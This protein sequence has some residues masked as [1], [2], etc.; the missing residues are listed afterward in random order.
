MVNNFKYINGV[1]LQQISSAIIDTG[2]FDTVQNLS[3]GAIIWCKTDYIDLL[4]DRLKH[5]NNKY[6]L[7][8]H[9]SDYSI[10]EAK[11]NSKPACIQRWFAQNVDYKHNQLTPLPIG[12]ENHYGPNKG[13][14]LD[15]QYILNSNN[16]YTHSPSK[17]VDRVYVNFTC[18]TNPNYRYNCI[19]ELTTNNLCE[20]HNKLPQ[21]EWYNDMKKFLFIA[22]PRGNGID[23]H[24]TWEALFNGSIPLVDRHFMFDEY[25]NLPII[26]IDNWK[27]VTSEFLQPYI[28]KYDNYTCFDNTQELMLDFWLNKITD[29]AKKLQ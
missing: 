5:C 18:S 9:C 25:K 13:S 22:S 3:S 16:N 19:N 26:Q 15:L 14:E 27:D 4:F 2:R 21:A 20:I 12:L 10:D 24:R 11:F 8:T 1:G 7:I 17:I 6:V 28:E 23:C 29:V